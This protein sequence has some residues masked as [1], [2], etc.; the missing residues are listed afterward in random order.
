MGL[1]DIFKKKDS[2][3]NTK[4]LIWKN[5]IFKYNACI[6]LLQNNPDA[7]WICWFNESKK[8]FLEHQG[9]PN[10]NRPEVKM[11]KTI[12]P[13]NVEGKTVF[14]LEHY[15]I[16]SEEENLIQHWNAKEIFI[17]NA[18]D[19]PLFKQF[20][21]DNVIG[22]MEKL[23]MRDDEHIEHSMISKSIKNAQKKIQEKVT[24]ESTA[25]SAAE[26]FRINIG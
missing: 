14:F 2:L 10:I 22:I 19:E 8:E 17:L 25:N 5:K 9:F 13:Y 12:Q 24:I 16:N 23:G 11:A 21:G 15:P 3:P 4:D 7:V 20:G 26:W 6:N 1:F 18:L